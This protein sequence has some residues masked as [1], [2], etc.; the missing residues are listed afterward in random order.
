VEWGKER[1]I[2]SAGIVITK[3][4]TITLTS[5]GS[6]RKVNDKVASSWFRVSKRLISGRM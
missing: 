5:G 4:T 2:G 6:S 1:I 3:G